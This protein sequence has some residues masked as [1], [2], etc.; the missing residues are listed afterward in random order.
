MGAWPVYYVWPLPSHLISESSD[1][2]LH[3]HTADRSW[4]ITMLLIGR[5]GQSRAQRALAGGC[6]GFYSSDLDTAVHPGICETE[7]F[8]VSIWST[9]VMY[10]WIHWLPRNISYLT[11]MS[12]MVWYRCGPTAT[13]SIEQKRISKYRQRDFFINSVFNRITKKT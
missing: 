10:M 4:P 7:L 2:W 13:L 9:T 12:I 6:S 11:Q 3:T 1:N 8:H 5:H